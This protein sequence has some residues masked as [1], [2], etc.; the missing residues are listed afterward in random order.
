[1]ARQP[2]RAMTTTPDSSFAR[3]GPIFL[4]AR[5]LFI[6]VE[7]AH[8]TSGIKLIQ[9][10]PWHRVSSQQLPVGLVVVLLLTDVLPLHAETRHP[11]EFGQGAVQ[12]RQVLDP[13]KEQLDD[14]MIDTDMA[15]LMVEWVAEDIQ[16][17]VELMIEPAGDHLAVVEK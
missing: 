3:M 14:R 12:S 2:E 7:V 17:A 15:L 5:T 1:M 8:V 4:Q 16:P 9:H 13:I 11:E 10:L 6:A